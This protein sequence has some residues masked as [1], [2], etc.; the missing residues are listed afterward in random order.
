MWWISL[1]FFIGVYFFISRATVVFYLA[2][3]DSS[4]AWRFSLTGERESMPIYIPVAGDI[5]FL[6]V[7]FWLLF[8]HPLLS[9]G[10]FG[11][12]IRTSL[13]EK[14]KRKEEVLKRQKEYLDNLALY[15]LTPQDIPAY[16]KEPEA[17]KEY[18][19]AWQMVNGKGRTHA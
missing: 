11:T 15:G 19:A 10:N 6:L 9:I 4:E 8:Y 14:K 5:Y 1:F 16:A 12:W 7:I 17:L 3:T 13:Q 2:L 18:L